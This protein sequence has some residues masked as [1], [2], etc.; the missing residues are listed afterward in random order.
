MTVDDDVTDVTVADN[1][2]S[3][4][5]TCG[6]RAVVPSDWTRSERPAAAA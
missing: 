3:I 2:V 5:R 4:G 1:G 6:V